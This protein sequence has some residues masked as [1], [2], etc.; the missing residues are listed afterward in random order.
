M[1]WRTGCR[2]LPACGRPDIRPGSTS[3]LRG[4][5]GRRRVVTTLA[6]LLAGAGR[7]ARAQPA[8]G[9]APVV[10]RLQVRIVID[11]LTD[12]SSLSQRDAGLGAERTGDTKRL[13]IAPHATLRAEW[14]LYDFQHEIAT[15]HVGQGR[16]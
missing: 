6:A 2:L 3:F 9:L 8:V 13:G 12:C 5:L 7:R 11:D 1:S 15:S 10:S 4:K 16:G 14:G